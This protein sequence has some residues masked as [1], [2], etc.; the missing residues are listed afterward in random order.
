M[1]IDG[2]G[3][4]D[5]AKLAAE[6][7]VVG[8]GP[9]GVVTA[10]ELARRGHDVLLVE[11]GR[12]QFDAATQELAEADLVDADLHAD[13]RIATRR[14]V[15]GT[16]VI[17]GGR[18]V[19]FDPIDFEERKHVPGARWP[20]TYDEIAAYFDRACTWMV[21]G[22]AVF[23]A[24]Q[25]PSWPRP[26]ADHIADDDEVRAT[27]LERWSLPTNFG[28]VYRRELSDTPNL[29]L[30]TGL[31]AV[32]VDW[33][34]ADGEA[35][36]LDCRT[37][38]GGRVTV[39]AGQFVLACGGLETT[40]LLLASPGRSSRVA[41]GNHSDQLGR[42]YMGH[43]EG[44]V[45]D[46][47]LAGDPRATLSGFERDVDG[48]YVR[49]RFTFTED[50]IHAEELPN[51]ALWFANPSYGDASHGSG[52]LSLAYLILASPAGRFLASEAQR[53]ALLGE[54][55]P[56]SP[57]PAAEPSPLR[58]HLA[59]LVRDPRGTAQLVFGF[60]PRRFLAR[61]RKA[62]GFFRHSATNTYPL[63]YHAEHFPHADSRVTLSERRDR[64][65]MPLLSIDVRFSDEDVDG[66]VRSHEIL[67]GYL[68]RTGAGRLEYLH[69]DPAAAVRAHIGAGFHQAGTTRMSAHPDEGVVDGDLAVHG[70][71]NVHVAS[72]SVFVTSGQANSTFMI[73]AFAV[74]LADHLSNRLRAGSRTG[75]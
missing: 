20:V 29:R 45:A 12:D 9:G 14:Q 41:L 37:P 2:T 27:S 44:V 36:A 56:G 55:V 4:P 66:I 54:Y 33:S 64:L 42:W 65:G 16:S 32:S 24:R 34:E 51:V 21:C 13:M 15:G 19:P 22:R 61:G 39:Q 28:A 69:A 60:A 68:Q 47:R 50:V 48:F 71:Q 5:G 11:S 49:R 62:P 74:R 6:V 58:A 17:W 10:L 8:S 18:C 25:L 53:R 59:N 57:T 1:N 35:R 3:L 38:S 46:V 43:V 40:R 72:S 30:V 70:V 73:V 63:Q 31:T 7:V 67:D 75:A 23:D 26:L 52:L